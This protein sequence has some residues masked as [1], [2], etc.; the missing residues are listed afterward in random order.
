MSWV[1]PGA[2]TMIRVR[3]ATPEDV[4]AISE[5]TVRGWQVAF[6]ELFPD[7]YL[8]ALDPRDRD[9]AF[10]ERVKN[11]PPNHA[12]V[13]EDDEVVGFVGLEPPE[14]EA[15]DPNRVHEIW[16]LYIEPEW[17]GTGV[18]R[19]LMDHALDHMQRGSWEHAILWTLRDVDQLS[20]LRSRR[21]VPRRG[22]E[23]LGSRRAIL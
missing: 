14:D 17:I 15:L 11:A 20:V 13:A 6:R 22:G 1:P 5:I 7:E 16:G 23:G 19:I 9:A 2:T 8:D 4:S 21:L 10:A 12:A 18:G 3:T